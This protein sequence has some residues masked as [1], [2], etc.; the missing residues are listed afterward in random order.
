MT[1]AAS[2]SPGPS[3]PTPPP[4]DAD[5]NRYERM[6]SD[7]VATLDPARP[8]FVTDAAGLAELWLANLPG[9]RQYYTCRACL[10]FI[11]RYGGLAHVDER[12]HLTSALWA[13]RQGE[14]EVPRFFLWADIAL[15]HK[16]SGAEVEGVFVSD[17]AVWGRPRTG[18]WS[19]LSGPAA[20]LLHEGGAE[21]AGQKAARLRE[22]YRM[23]RR[24]LAEFGPAVVDAAVRVL[25]AEALPG[26]EKALGVARWL[27]RL[28]KDAALLAR[29]QSD[30]LRWLAAAA[31]P[32]GW[33][34]VRSSM[35]GTLLEDILLGLPFDAVR[36]R[37]AEK[38]HPL[39]YMRPSAPP[40]A[41]AIDRA[42]ALVE[43]LGLARS[44]QRRYARLDE[45]V[46]LWLPHATSAPPPAGGVFS[47][48]RPAGP[49]ALE[50]PARKMTWRRFCAEVLPRAEAIDFRVPGAGPFFAL[51]T[52]VHADAPPLLRW[53]G[54]PRNPVGWFFRA[55][56]S[57]AQRWSLAPGAW[58]RVA[59]V[60]LKPCHWH[61]PDLHREQGE[62]AMLLLEGCRSAEDGPGG[63]FFPSQLRNELHEARAVLEAHALRATLAGRREATAC[64]YAL[65]R[66]AQGD[67]NCVLRCVLTGAAGDSYHID[68]WE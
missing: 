32:K 35:I 17:E 47:H 11:G 68:R 12:G 9:D 10:E 31:A 5:Y 22:E 13:G 30:A 64:G 60:C 43:R 42:E 25:E 18:P 6:V 8:L 37:W 33:C 51:T 39:Q 49:P 34:H 19:H 26:S 55:H 62:A 67:Y 38:V 7:R 56:G 27:Q 24:G 41:Q 52:A 46:P 4:S 14:G 16:V 66:G 61:R 21:S 29:P 23:L 50:L 40:A 57:T 65:Q 53:D 15:C 1:H 20:Q 44:L 59:A 63:G 28:H 2:P 36:R 58:A 48:L 54:D 3:R 45:V